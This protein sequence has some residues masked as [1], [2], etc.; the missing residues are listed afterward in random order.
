V[1]EEDT[2]PPRQNG[3]KSSF[4]ASWQCTSEVGPGAEIPIEGLRR[5]A[6]GATLSSFSTFIFIG[7]EGWLWDSG[8][9]QVPGEGLVL[10]RSIGAPVVALIRS[11]G[12]DIQSIDER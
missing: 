5:A 3:A 2:P 7:C 9:E 8:A 10:R 11:C 12:E 4:F 6:G 1:V